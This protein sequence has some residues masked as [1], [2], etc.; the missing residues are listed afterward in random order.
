MVYSKKHRFSKS[1]L[2]LLILFFRTN[3]VAAYSIFQHHGSSAGK[4]EPANVPSKQGA[5]R[6]ELAT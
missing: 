2:S 1:R 3:D 5:A 4:R 6:P